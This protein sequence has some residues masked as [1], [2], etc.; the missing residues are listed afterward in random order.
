MITGVG[1]GIGGKVVFLGEGGGYMSEK[2]FKLLME[3]LEKESKEK[4][5]KEEALRR[6]VSAG[7]LD[8]SGN[9][10]KPYECLAVKS[11]R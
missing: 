9:L 10:T 7:I 3:L 5:S 4:V 6:L 2:D 8:W 11:P 1:W